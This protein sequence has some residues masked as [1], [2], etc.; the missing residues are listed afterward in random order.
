MAGYRL[1]I[2][3]AAVVVMEWFMGIAMSL[4]AR[5]RF[6][7]LGCV[8]QQVSERAVSGR[9]RCRTSRKPVG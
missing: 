8:A 1:L 3:A 4:V 9:W 7:L 2:G 6:R 5:C